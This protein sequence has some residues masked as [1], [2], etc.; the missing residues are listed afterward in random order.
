MAVKLRGTVYKTSLSN[1]Q[2]NFTFQNSIFK[3]CYNRRLDS[4]V[5]P[6]SCLEIGSLGF[7]IY[8][9]IVG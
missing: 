2:I 3:A 8:L 6:P 4:L 7:E 9:D 1:F 5:H